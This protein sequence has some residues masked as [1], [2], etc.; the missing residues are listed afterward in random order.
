M[1]LQFLELT[2][3]STFFDVDL[4]H[5]PILVTGPS[6]MSI[7]I[8]SGVV[9]ISFYKKLT[10][11][12]EIRNTLVRVLPN[13]WRRGKLGKLIFGTNFYNEMLLNALKYQ[14][15]SFYR[16]AVIRENP[17]SPT[18]PPPATQDQILNKCSK[19]YQ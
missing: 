14:S 18:P 4:F 17:P 2:S 13:I 9:M 16:L 10:R 7:S 1:T 8:S 11:N 12:K 5:L 6:F 3:S 15:Y 19:D